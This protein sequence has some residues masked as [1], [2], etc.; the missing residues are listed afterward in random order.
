MFS[1]LK[2]IVS[3]ILRINYIRINVVF[4]FNIFPDP[5]LLIKLNQN[6]FIKFGCKIINEFG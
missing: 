3:Y 5:M 1:V 4:L 2:K 6:V